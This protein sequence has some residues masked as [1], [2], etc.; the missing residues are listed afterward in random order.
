[1]RD[2]LRDSFCCEIHTQ[3]KRLYP[4]SKN[5]NKNYRKK[6][7]ENGYVINEYQSDDKHNICYMTSEKLF[8]DIIN[9]HDLSSV[10]NWFGCFDELKN[11]NECS[12]MGCGSEFSIYDRNTKFLFE[13][14]LGRN[15]N[16]KISFA[17]K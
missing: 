17:L 12:L 4:L 6:L 16:L 9:K 2:E 10:F 3:I 15:H 13:M 8:M 7:I 5:Q 1:M 11:L 14:N